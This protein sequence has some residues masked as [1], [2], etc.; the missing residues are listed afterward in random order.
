MP[1]RQRSSSSHSVSPPQPQQRPQPPDPS[2]SHS[3]NSS[4]RSPSP[5][6]PRQQIPL[7]PPQSKRN[8]KGQSEDSR[9]SINAANGPSGNADNLQ[10]P[11]RIPARFEQGP[12][13]YKHPP[14]DGPLKTITL[15]SWL[16]EST[17]MRLFC[18]SF[19]INGSTA[20]SHRQRPPSIP[21]SI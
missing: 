12:D 3:H 5:P 7:K 9:Q 2:G 1:K 6:S 18:Y 19:L 8:R 13:G 14:L 15:P 20:A 16:T 4:R 10:D 17:C 21:Q 11:R